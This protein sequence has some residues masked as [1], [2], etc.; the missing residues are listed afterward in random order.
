MAWLSPLFDPRKRVDDGGD[1]I[2]ARCQWRLLESEMKIES[3]SFGSIRI[4][5]T[6]HEDDVVIDSGVVR[7]R[8]Q[9]PS[10]KF[11]GANCA[12]EITGSRSWDRS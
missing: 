4:D 6:I 5:G 12:A 1:N 11:R 7:K 9:K 2:S 3:F 10:R 8:D